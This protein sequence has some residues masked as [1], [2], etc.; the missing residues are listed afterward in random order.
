[1]ETL[2]PSVPLLSPPPPQ[3]PWASINRERVNKERTPAEQAARQAKLIKKDK[4][5]KQKIEAAGIE[6]EYK[7]YESTVQPKAKKIKFED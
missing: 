1:M 3:I 7:G 6:Y 4:K 2:P 5:R